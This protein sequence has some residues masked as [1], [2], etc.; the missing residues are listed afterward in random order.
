MEFLWKALDALPIIASS[1]LAFLGYAVTIA[2]WVYAVQRS[3]RLK[4]LLA[5]LRDVPEG[6]RTK[7]IQ[8]EL[9]EVLPPSISAEQWLRAKRQRYFFAAFVI[10]V[11]TV[12]ALIGAALYSSQAKL[13]ID[14]VRE[15]L[16][17]AKKSSASVAGF[18]LVQATAVPPPALDLAEDAASPLKYRYVFDITLRNPSDEPVN[19]TELRI[20]FDPR[21]GGALANVQEIS[22]TYVV[23]VGTDGATANTPVGRFQAYAW[24]PSGSGRLHVKTPLS[25]TLAPKSTDRIR[26]VVEFPNDYS[27]SGPMEEAELQVYWNAKRYERSAPISLAK[28]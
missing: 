14:D 28:R 22:G 25:Q 24:Y 20:V 26:I 23:Q 21:K 2:A 11:L 15:V 13:V 6:E 18:M 17:P 27:F 5:R 10:L 9:N 7:L 3:Q 12:A 16:P 8:L 19:A 4:L 1:P